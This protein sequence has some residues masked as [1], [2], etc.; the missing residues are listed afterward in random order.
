MHYG[1]DSHRHDALN[2]AAEVAR[3]RERRQMRGVRTLPSF[4]LVILCVLLVPYWTGRALWRLYGKLR[5]KAPDLTPP[6]SP[7]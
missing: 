1:F 4:I 6:P 2:T 7:R 5:P 3:R